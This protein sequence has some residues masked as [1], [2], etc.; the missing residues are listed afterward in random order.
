MVVNFFNEDEDA[1][2]DEHERLGV[3]SRLAVHADFAMRFPESMGG[4]GSGD[5]NS[6]S[7]GDSYCEMRRVLLK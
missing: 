7:N 2:A 5:G 4:G 3:K 1:A 6:I